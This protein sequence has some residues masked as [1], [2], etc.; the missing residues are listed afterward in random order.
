MLSY[1][2]KKI[3]LKFPLNNGGQEVGISEGGIEHFTGKLVESLCKEI[4]QNS[5]DARRKGEIVKIDF[6]LIEMQKNKIPLID[7]LKN[8]IEKCIRYWDKNEKAKN[9]L[10]KSFNSIDKEFIQVL[11]V[12]D[13]GTCGLTGSVEKRDSNFS[14]L[15]K[16]S[17]ASSKGGQSG[18]SFGIGKFA[19]FACSLPRTI[20]Y[21]TLDIDGNYAFQGVSRLVT[22]ELN[23]ETTQG[24]G[25]IGNPDGNLPILDKNLIPPSFLR[26]E[27]GTDINII[28]FSSKEDWK[29]SIIKSSL[30]S[31]FESIYEGKLEIKVGNIIINKNNFKELGERFL[32]RSDITYEY[33]KCIIE[34][35][36]DHKSV[37][38]EDFIYK[39]ENYGQ[40][41]LHLYKEVGF[42]KKISY[43]RS[44]GMKIIDKDRFRTSL[45]FSGVLKLNG[46]KI[47][48]F[49]RSL[50]TPSH[51]KLEVERAENPK[52]AKKI[53]TSLNDFVKNKIIE[54]SKINEGEELDV[55]G[56]SKFLPDDSKENEILN[57]SLQNGAIKT[58]TIEKPKKKKKKK[59]I[60]DIK[61]EQEIIEG[62]EIEDGDID[63]GENPS[64]ETIPTIN[65]PGEGNPKPQSPGG[66][67][68]EKKDRN[69]IPLENRL[70]QIILKKQR[71][72]IN[73]SEGKK[74][75]IILESDKKRT[76]YIQLKSIYEDGGGE[77]VKISNSYGISNIIPTL[78]SKTLVSFPLEANKKEII[79]VELEENIYSSMEVLTSEK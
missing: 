10:T 61:N 57:F 51:D 48:S 53:L 15:V 67:A 60:K 71:A 64:E 30:K 19:P 24:V 1:S 74:Y 14:N 22:H 49:I 42:K 46:N 23:G 29:D 41:E 3:E 11:R 4:L 78:E 76:V 8:T 58:I 56:L 35:E 44:T 33:F 12:S 63:T 77:I 65:L 28:G 38:I 20:F 31:F 13:Y 9:V 39:K 69:P 47:N 73:D 36:G 70:N 18:G 59:K 75:K 6:E 50:E 79:F 27:I 5:L 52:E 68:E 66:E 21:S 40:L 2:K 72:L 45:N 32:E 25:Y 17:G 62:S 54:F 43:L 34:N 26:E 7:D 16:S 55:K 37:F